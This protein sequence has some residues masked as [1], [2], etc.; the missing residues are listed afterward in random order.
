M[1]HTTRRDP[2][3]GWQNM[4]FVDFRLLAVMGAMILVSPT[5]AAIHQHPAGMPAH[6]A[7][8]AS[9]AFHQ[10]AGRVFHRTAGGERH[11]ARAGVV[12]AGYT[13]HYAHRLGHRYGYAGA[14]Y[15]GGA[16]VVGTYVGGEAYPDYGGGYRYIHRSCRWY[17]YHEPYNTP[18]RCRPHGYAYSYEYGGPSYAVSYG[19]GH[20][21]GHNARLAWNGGRHAGHHPTSLVRATHIHV[22]HATH[23]AGG[24]QFATPHGGARIAR[25]GGHPKLH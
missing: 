7:S 18:Y 14:G 8:P 15:Y 22:S 25:I 3:E 5:N 11:L 16:A 9:Q 17:Y 6:R 19:F 23:F 13:R 24:H 20:W 21:H 10:S 2:E 4:K 1:Q 12:H